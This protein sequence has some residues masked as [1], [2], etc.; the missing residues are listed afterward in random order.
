MARKKKVDQLTDPAYYILLSLAEAKHGYSIMK[1]IE[2][3]TEGEMLVGPAT[4]YTH[5]KKLQDADLIHLYGEEEER[6]KTYIATKKGVTLLHQE[7]DRRRNM[8]AHAE[9]VFK[10]LG[11]EGQ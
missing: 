9:R 10:K 11:G 2:E 6:R 3:M 7:V 5:L 1:E 8:V 4:L